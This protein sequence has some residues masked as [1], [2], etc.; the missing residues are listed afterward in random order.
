MT[1]RR[2]GRAWR[3]A[4]A[5]PAILWTALFFVVPL[6]VMAVQSLGQRVAGQAMPGLDARELRP[7]LRQALF[8]R[9]AAQL[10]RGDG[11]GTTVVSV[12]LAYPLAWILAYPGAGSAGS[13]WR[14]CSWRSCRSGPP[15]WSAPTAGCWSWRPRAWCLGTL[16]SLGIDLGVP[17]GQQ[18]DRHGD[19]LRPLLHHAAD[20][21]DLRQP[22]SRSRPA[23]CAPPPTSAPRPGRPSCA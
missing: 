8:L 4:C 15:I 10:A 20:A 6:V 13:V 18:P 17:A 2:A 14:S 12:L 1:R 5:G 11:A 21:D 7:V 19:R 23:T 16:R 9:G 22:R 3:L